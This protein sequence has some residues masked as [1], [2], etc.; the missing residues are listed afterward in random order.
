MTDAFAASRLA[1]R[2]YENTLLS[3]CIV[4]E[5]LVRPKYIAVHGPGQ[6]TMKV[7]VTFLAQQ[8]GLGLTGA[9]L[10]AVRI[11]RNHDLDGT[12]KRLLLGR[13]P[14]VPSWRIEEDL[15]VMYALRDPAAHQIRPSS[16]SVVRFWSLSESIL[17]AIFFVTERLYA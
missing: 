2:I 1:A 16:G 9:D 6:H 13:M 10:D 3:L 15:K 8:T 4:F 14:G 17:R 12:L 5:E 11:A 7:L